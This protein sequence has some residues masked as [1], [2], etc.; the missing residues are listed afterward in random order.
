MSVDSR[1][2]IIFDVIVSSKDVT[3]EKLPLE[4]RF[5]APLYLLAKAVKNDKKDGWVLNKDLEKKCL[6]DG[7]DK[8]KHEIIKAFKK[9]IGKRADSIIGIKYG[10]AKK[11]MLPKKNIKFKRTK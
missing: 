11:W 5:L 2:R 1:C 3:N 7:A 8:A 4:D 10:T 9:I 6:G